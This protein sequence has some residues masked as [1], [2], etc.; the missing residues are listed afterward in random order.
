MTVLNFSRAF[1]SFII[2]LTISSLSLSS[3]QQAYCDIRYRLLSDSGDLVAV[4]R[5][6]PVPEVT[7][8]DH[9]REIKKELDSLLSVPIQDVN[10]NQNR[11][12]NYTPITGNRLVIER[13]RR[14]GQ[15]ILVDAKTGNSVAFD[16]EF[17]AED[18]RV[19]QIGSLRIVSKTHK[20]LVI[21]RANYLVYP[22]D[23]PATR[24]VSIDFGEMKASVI[25]A[26]EGLDYYAIDE[27]GGLAVYSKRTHD[28]SSAIHIASSHGTYEKIGTVPG[29]VVHMSVEE[30]AKLINIVTESGYKQFDFYQFD[31]NH[32]LTIRQLI[33]ANISSWG[34]DSKTAQLLWIEAN[35]EIIEL[36][37]SKRIPSDSRKVLST[38]LEDYHDL[39]LIDRHDIST[40]L[41]RAEPRS[42]SSENYAWF[43]ILDGSFDKLESCG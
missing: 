3:A 29:R 40:F 31:L 9:K 13:N 10:E 23:V 30:A 5:T 18:T 19:R 33:Y 11:F 24:L 34:F 8:F 38:I 14:L 35:S 26:P 22:T 7:I 43:L 17:S 2:L 4:Q 36:E 15:F 20:D 27:S 28:G 41:I 39:V 37:R 1:I 42:A 12:L 21:Q 16:P 6:E 32:Q 25:P